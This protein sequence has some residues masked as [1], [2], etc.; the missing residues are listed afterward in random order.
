MTSLSA[1]TAEESFI[2]DISPLQELTPDVI[3]KNVHFFDIEP[4]IQWIMTS[5]KAVSAQNYSVENEPHRVVINYY[6][7]KSIRTNVSISIYDGLNLINEL[8]DSGEAGLNS[9][10]WGMTKRKQNR[11]PEEIASYD[12]QVA[13]ARLNYWFDYYDPVGFYG[14]ADEEVDKYGHSLRTHVHIEPDIRS[15]EHIL[16][17]VSP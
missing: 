11:T 4:K 10:E 1:H 3:E 5:Q 16:V 8:T 13:S 9:V 12:Q 15:R 7:K 2:T 14:D 6:L 17:R